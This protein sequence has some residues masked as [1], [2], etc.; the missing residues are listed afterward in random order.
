M[1]NDGWLPLVLDGNTHFV[2]IRLDRVEHRTEAEHI[3][4]LL[5]ERT[6]LLRRTNHEEAIRVICDTRPRSA[7]PLGL[8]ALIEYPNARVEW[9][10]PVAVPDSLAL[11][12]TDVGR[13]EP[14]ATRLFRSFM[15]YARAAIYHLPDN[16]ASA[17]RKLMMSGVSNAPPEAVV[18]GVS[19]PENRLLVYMRATRMPKELPAGAARATAIR[20]MQA[21]LEREMDAIQLPVLD[22]VAA[23]PEPGWFESKLNGDSGVHLYMAIGYCAVTA[24]DQE[25]ASLSVKTPGAAVAFATFAPYAAG[26]LATMPVPSLHRGARAGK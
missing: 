22:G 3:Q 19:L 26:A 15:T 5:E 17:M 11:F 25:C 23:V 12:G 21:A 18:C 16:P 6:S 4:K 8:R 2:R 20:A 1:N 9:V 24:H 13:D 10:D 14:I 7:W